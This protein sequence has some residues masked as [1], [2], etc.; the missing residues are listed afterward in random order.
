MG[1]IAI[2]QN[3]Q[4][5]SVAVLK[6]DIIPPQAQA[7]LPLRKQP[8]LYTRY[9]Q[10]HIFHQASSLC[11]RN[12]TSSSTESRCLERQTQKEGQRK[13]RCATSSEVKEKAS[14]KEAKMQEELRA[15]CEAG[16]VAQRNFFYPKS[17]ADSQQNDNA[18]N[19]DENEQHVSMHILF[20]S[21]PSEDVQHDGVAGNAD[22]DD[23]NEELLQEL[24]VCE[25]SPPDIEVTHGD[26][27]EVV[28]V[29][30]VMREYL[31]VVVQHLCSEIS[32]EAFK[33]VNNQWCLF[34]GKEEYRLVEKLILLVSPSLNFDKMAIK[35]CNYVDGID[36]FPK[37]PVYL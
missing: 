1:N 9:N 32:D 37:L 36:I 33:N 34:M 7:I 14:R 17:S 29:A 15:R 12:E 10:L 22:A 2:K 13:R 5:G 16:I 30:G 3:C 31:R 8:R 20:S 21:N 4:D 26:V 18:N 11:S 24:N 19:A 35:W 23:N 25:V 28:E 27:H 6:G